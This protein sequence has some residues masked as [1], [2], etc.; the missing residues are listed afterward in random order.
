MGI[1][2]KAIFVK[3]RY[4]NTLTISLYPIYIHKVF[5]VT[6]PK[7]LSVH[8]ERGFFSSVVRPAYSILT[9]ATN[10][11]LFFHKTVRPKRQNGHRRPEV[12]R[13]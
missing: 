4:I 2:G 12:R 6:P 13:R 7:P 8:S 1:Y 9:A 10:R 3:V 11:A 5:P